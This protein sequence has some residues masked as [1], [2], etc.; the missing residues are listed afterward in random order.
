MSLPGSVI[1]LRSPEGRR[2]VRQVDA[3][4]A[5][6]RRH[7]KTFAIA[8]RLLPRRIR[9]DVYL[10]Y[11]VFRTLD[12]LVDT[13]QPEAAARIAA[14][15]AWAEEREGEP[16]A[17]VERLE[18]LSRRY[19]IDRGAIADFCRGMER[20]LH[21]ESFA[22][23]AELDAY[24][25]EVAGTVGIVMSGL[26][27][28]DGS[29]KA[30]VAA[31]RLGMAMQRTNILRDLDEDRRAGRTYVAEESLARYGTPLPGAR[32]AFVAEQIARADALY[33]QGLAGVERLR[34][35]RLA[36]AAA[37]RMYREILREIERRDG[38]ERPGRAVVS[39][40]RKLVV[41]LGALRYARGSRVLAR[42]S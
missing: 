19:W 38:G 31:A 39:R 7:A 17:E 34:G 8:C 22:T 36:V 25:Y 16:T 14:V 13:G 4:R 18:E 9:G 5:V 6:T 3:A 30:R 12:D 42:A 28:S 29:L 10:L 41:G 21:A 35:G 37:A 33:D 27:G 26:L 24:C 1:T 20:D 2:S 15:A 40:R 32:A 23:E 11:T